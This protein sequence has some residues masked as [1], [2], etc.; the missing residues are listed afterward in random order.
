MGSGGEALL[1]QT[2]NAIRTSMAAGLRIVFWIGAIATLISF[3]LIIT[4]PEIP[5]GSKEEK[6]GLE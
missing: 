6:S 4:I 1:N 3:L 5:I 2:V